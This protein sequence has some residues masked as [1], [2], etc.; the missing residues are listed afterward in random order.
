MEELNK[1]VAS[2]QSHYCRQSDDTGHTAD[3]QSTDVKFT[4][5]PNPPKTFNGLVVYIIILCVILFIAIYS[6]VSLLIIGNMDEQWTSGSAGTTTTT[7][8]NSTATTRPYDE[9]R[10]VLDLSGSPSNGEYSAVDA[11]QKI[12][13]SIVSMLVYQNGYLKSTGSGVIMTEDGYII[14]CAHIVN[15]NGDSM[16]YRVR[17]YD[18]TEYDAQ[19]IGYDDKTDI[20]VIKIDVNGLVPAEFASSDSLKSGQ[21]ILAVGSPGGLDFAGSI[22]DG[23]ISSPNRYISK[24]NVSNFRVIQHTAAINPGNSGGA[25]INMYGQVVGI[26]SAK[27]MA[28]D[29]EG[30]GF[31]VSISYVKPFIDD[32][33]QYGSVVRRGMIGV[34][35]E[36]IDYLSK[37]ASVVSENKLPP[38]TI[39]ITSIY[40]SSD[41]NNYNV[42]TGDLLI[43]INGKKLTSIDIL[44][45]IVYESSVGETVTLELFRP[46]TK[47]I[48]EVTCKF[49]AES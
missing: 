26:N 38:A 11:A 13:P 33:I 29:Y 27:I 15:K 4:K 36:Q 49:V 10:P 48:F 41:L 34:D 47:E 44:F 43:G 7:T 31:A 20:A 39:V 37:Y 23:I 18:N 25:L 6:I 1:D 30:M 3:N 42:K 28:T 17:L 24:G 45:D 16:H 19:V 22:T 8:Q 35:Y 12:A 9:N 5:Y 46:E 2:Q 14:T 40:K 32:I 21:D